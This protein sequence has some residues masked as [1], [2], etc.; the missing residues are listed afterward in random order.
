MNIFP[1]KRGYIFFFWDP[2]YLL[3]K[4]D[5]SFNISRLH[6]KA[7]VRLRTFQLQQ[8]K[9]M[10]LVLELPRMLAPDFPTNCY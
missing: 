5:K 8:S 6:K 4:E 3:L 1:K 9:N 2:F 10:L 7:K